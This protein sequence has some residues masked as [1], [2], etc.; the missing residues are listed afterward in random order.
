MTEFSVDFV[1]RELAQICDEHLEC[2]QKGVHLIRHLCNLPADILP[3]GRGPNQH[4]HLPSE[5]L[6]V[7]VVVTVHDLPRENV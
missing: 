2:L 4:H 3:R 1:E 7:S 6:I 5:P